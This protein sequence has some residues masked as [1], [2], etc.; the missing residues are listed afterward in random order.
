M[1]LEDPSYALY[2]RYSL[3]QERAGTEEVNLESHQSTWE[4][5]LRTNG[6]RTFNELQRY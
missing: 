5:E 3:P 2:A 1:I 4:I 6:W